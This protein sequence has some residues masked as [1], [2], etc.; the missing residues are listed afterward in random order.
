MASWVPYSPMWLSF[1]GRIS[2]VR[3]KRDP[4]LYTPRKGSSS[5]S[6]ENS[7]RHPPLLEPY[8]PTEEPE[9]HYK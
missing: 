4:G 6:W 9:I 1:S 7:S 2:R 5:L 8:P 3:E